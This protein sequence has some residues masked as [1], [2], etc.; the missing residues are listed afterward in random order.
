M[1]YLVTGANGY[2]GRHVVAALL[3][4]GN[5]VVAADLSYDGVDV[6]AEFSTVSLFSGDADIYEQFGKP[7][8][9]IHLA[10]RNGFVHNN[11]SHIDDLPGHYTFIKNMIDGG[12]K[13]IVVMGTMHEVG[14]FEGAINETSPCNPKSLYGISKN[15]LRQ[16]TFMVAEEKNV[17]CQWLRGY[18]ILGDDIKNHSIFTKL[19]ESAEAGKKEFPFTTGKNKYDFIDVRELARQIAAVAM[20]TEVTGVIN[21]CSGNPVSLADQV[22]AYIKEHNLDIKLQYGAF[23]DRPYDSPGVWGDATKIK[24]IMNEK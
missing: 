6:R 21:C 17:C 14:Y 3:E 2:V 23:P 7:D 9:C 8:V 4:Q 5:K 22:E 18:Y 19:L 10:W 16:M 24:A 20:Q 13:H 11:P 1:K 15:A 12:L